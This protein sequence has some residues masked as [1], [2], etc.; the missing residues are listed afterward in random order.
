[1]CSAHIL[2]VPMRMLCQAVQCQMPF[3]TRAQASPES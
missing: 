2:L 1:M 3:L